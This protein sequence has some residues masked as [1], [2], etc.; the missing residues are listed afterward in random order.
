[1]SKTFKISNRLMI[2]SFNKNNERDFIMNLKT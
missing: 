1:M 2:R